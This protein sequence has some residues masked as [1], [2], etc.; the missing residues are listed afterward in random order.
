[1]DALN[2]SAAARARRLAA[3]FSLIVGTMLCAAKFWAAWRTGSAAVL[4]DALESILNI[5]AA[6]LLWWTVEVSARPADRDHPYGHGKAE[7]FSAG[8][9]GALI[10]LAAFA[11]LF[12]AVPRL[13]A[14]RP[15]GDLDL[16]LLVVLG[17][18]VVNGALGLWLVRRGQALRSAALVADGRHVLTDTLTSVGVVVGLLLVRWTGKLWIDPLVACLVAAQILVSGGKLVRGAVGRLMDE[19]DLR[20]LDQIASALQQSRRDDWVDVHQLRT[21]RS[22]RYLHVDFHLTVP[23]YWSVE[24]GHTAEKDAGAELLQR[25]QED[26]DVIVHVDPCVPECCHL[27]QVAPCP[28]RS[29]PFEGQIDWTAPLLVAP[30]AEVRVRPPRRSIA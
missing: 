8:V 24:R 22:G 7:D 12:E 6:A 10:V 14:P 29:A 15:I 19:A 30:G 4:S 18:G 9:E 26:G 28:V 2:S 23:R 5:A 27:C 3:T 16:G 25:L 17:A 21:W 11:I 1:M 13:L 20:L